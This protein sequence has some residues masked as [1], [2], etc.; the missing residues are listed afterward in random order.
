M[1]YGGSGLWRAL[2]KLPTCFHC[3]AVLYIMLLASS[4][5]C[6]R[7][8]RTCQN[9]RPPKIGGH[10]LPNTS[11][12][13]NAGPVLDFGFGLG[14]GLLCEALAV[15]FLH[16]IQHSFGRTNIWSIEFTEYR[17]T[18]FSFSRINATV[19]GCPNNRNSNENP[20]YTLMSM[21]A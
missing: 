19:F 9:W 15:D 5:V 12:M 18:Y 17:P 11:N 8:P 7:M 4:R 6:V 3:T 1:F 16:T 14:L 10:F 21:N 20:A 2:Y 13:P